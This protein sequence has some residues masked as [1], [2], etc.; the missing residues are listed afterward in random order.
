MT[1]LI[2]GLPTPPAASLRLD[3]RLFLSHESQSNNAALLLRPC[4]VSGQRLPQR[5]CKPLL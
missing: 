1:A 4:G 2:A 3:S 5:P